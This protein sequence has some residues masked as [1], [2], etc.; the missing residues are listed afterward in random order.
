MSRT[1][2][3]G[4]GSGAGEEPEVTL[5]DLARRLAAI[6]ELI[7]PLVPLE[8]QVPALQAT[9]GGLQQQQATTTATLTRLDNT[10]RAIG[11]ANG[12]RRNAAEEE[13][14]PEFPTVHKVEFPKYDDTG[15]PLPWLNRCDRYFTVRRTPEHK[16][17]QYTSLHLPDD[18]QLWY[19]RLELNNGPP[20]WTRFVQLV[21]IRFRP[22]LIDNSIGE[23]ALLR[24]AG[25]VDDYCKQFMALSCRD[26]AISEAH[27]I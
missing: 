20:D 11:G 4:N 23:L 15:D 6:E 18:A 12:R 1:S 5:Q 13:G 2:V 25:S 21:Q 9:V 24:H 22:P 16:K 10:V 27:Q 26:P 8:E 19:H 3:A 7:R 17:V 14:D